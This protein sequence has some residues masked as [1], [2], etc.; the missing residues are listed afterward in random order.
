LER[1]K[2]EIG[3]IGIDFNKIF[4]DPD[5]EENIYLQADDIITIPERLYT[6]TIDGGVNVPGSIYFEEGESLEY[7]I[8]AAGG[9]TELANE[10]NVLIRLANGKPVQQSR[11]R[12]WKSLSEDINPGSTIYVPV[13]QKKESIDWSATFRD[14]AAILGSIAALILIVNQIGK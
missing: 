6:V 7:Y 11:F 14:T 3:Q 4:S 1:N 10:D 2:N 12:F 13:L 8:N 9:F 5:L